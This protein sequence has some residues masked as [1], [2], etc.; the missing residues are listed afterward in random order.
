MQSQLPI[1]LSEAIEAEI[2]G[3]SGRALAAEYAGL[4]HAYREGLPSKSQ[5]D[6]KLY[7]L[8]YLVGRMPAT[9][10]AVQAALRQL[11]VPLIQDCE[12]LLDLGAGPGTASWV[13]AHYL[14]G[15]TSSH[16]I[17][18]NADA[19]A[20]GEKLSLAA[21]LKPRF[22]RADL[23]HA[24]KNAPEADLVILSYTAIEVGAGILEAAAAKAKKLFLLVEPGTP[25]GFKIILEARQKISG[26]V[27]PCPQRG[28]CPLATVDGKWCHFSARLERNRMAKLLKGGD[29]GYEDEKFSYAAFSKASASPAAGASRIIGFPQK[30]EGRIQFDLCSPQGL[31][32]PAISKFD[33]ALY[34]KAKK[35]EWGELWP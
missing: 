33:K 3:V 5:G 29:L 13:A 4:S 31:E 17:E 26:L 25:A 1:W 8:A 6:L 32:K 18:L 35:A 34:K 16:A 11:P 27:A 23:K 19:I 21:P 24:I 12:S 15:L 30:S 7:W 9:Y 22:E 28:D 20:L 2:H 10:A 14:P